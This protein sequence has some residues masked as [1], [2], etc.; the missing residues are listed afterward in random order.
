M[1]ASPAVA[2]PRHPSHGIPVALV[3]DEGRPAS[4][5]AVEAASRSFGGLTA[6]DE[7]SFE[8]A[9]G[10]ICGLIGP[11]GAGKTTLINAV[12][13]LTP[14]SQGRIRLGSTEISGLPPHRIAALGVARTFQ[15]VRLFGDLPVLESVM[16][17]HHLPQRCSLEESVR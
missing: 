4:L 16:V 9:E 10:S 1:P 17:G 8:V 14:L 6:L 11:N 3:S 2:P 13:G 5:L 7:V 12:S 15:T